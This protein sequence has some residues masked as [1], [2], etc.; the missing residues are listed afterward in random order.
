MC[1]DYIDF[2]E[3]PTTFQGHLINQLSS[4]V[5]SVS[6]WVGGG[7]GHPVIY[8]K[9]PEH[10]VRWFMFLLRQ[11]EFRT[12]HAYDLGSTPSEEP[13]RPASD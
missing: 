1:R 10:A 12:E 11:E 6:L 7:Q 2:V 4:E 9:G 5:P 8:L 13:T 3:C